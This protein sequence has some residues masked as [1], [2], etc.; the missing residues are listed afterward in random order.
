MARTGY[1][2]LYC[3]GADEPPA[4]SAESTLVATLRERSAPLAADRLSRRDRIGQLPLEER[5]ILSSLAVAVVVPI[6]SRGNLPGFVCLGPKRS[7][8]IYTSSELA[9]LTAVANVVSVRFSI[10]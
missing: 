7:C 4:F 10:P 8:D 5:A 3:M 6:R 2:A 1:E 9:L